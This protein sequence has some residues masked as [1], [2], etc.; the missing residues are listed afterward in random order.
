MSTVVY[1]DFTC[2][3]SYLASR[4][5][6]LLDDR[7]G[8]VEWRAVEHA[9]HTPLNGLRLDPEAAKDAEREWRRVQELLL[10]DEELPGR[11]PTVLS[12]TQAAVA[13]YAEAVGAGVGPAVRRL[14]FRAYWV[15]GLDIGNPEILRPLLAAT[16]RAGTSTSAP[17]HEF[18]Y[19]VTPARGPITSDAYRRIREWHKQWVS[20]GDPTIPTMQEDG[21][22]ISGVPALIRL[23]ERITGLD[24]VTAPSDECTGWTMDRLLPASSEGFWY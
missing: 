7:D 23:G 5:I 3:F 8:E 14:L 19:A 9:P 21:Q 24:S 6:D 12:S 1:G 11:P 20:L 10:P 15:D 4:R 16:V 2:P 13:A 18:G 22:T 17:L